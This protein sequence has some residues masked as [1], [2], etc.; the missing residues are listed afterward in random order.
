[1]TNHPG[2]WVALG[3]GVAFAGVLVL[4]ETPTFVGSTITA[5]GIQYECPSPWAM[6]TRTEFI[7]I[8]PHETYDPESGEGILYDDDD[9]E[10]LANGPG[11]YRACVGKSRERA[12]WA[13]GDLLI[14]FG[15][16]SYV[17]RRASSEPDDDDDA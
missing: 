7:D 15:V 1:M 12:A 4:T 9:L 6:W 5:Q 13:G 10:R 11:S 14:A 8:Y 17:W 3:V 2:S 16:A